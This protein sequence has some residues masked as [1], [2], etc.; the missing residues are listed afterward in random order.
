MA[1]EDLENG[2]FPDILPYHGMTMHDLFLGQLLTTHE[3][4]VELLRPQLGQIG[5]ATIQGW[6]DIIH[7]V[8]LGA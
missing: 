5:Y 2:V 3:Q 1:L 7:L 8:Q 4:M 6:L